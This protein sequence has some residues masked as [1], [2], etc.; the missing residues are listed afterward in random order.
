MT[1]GGG[2]AKAALSNPLGSNKGGI[3]DSLSPVLAELEMIRESEA[4]NDDEAP[5]QD[6]CKDADKDY[7]E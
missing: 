7:S 5:E 3:D 4:D 6:R 2:G 1:R